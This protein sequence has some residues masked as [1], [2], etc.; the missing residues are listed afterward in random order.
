MLVIDSILSTNCCIHVLVV[1]VGADRYGE[2]EEYGSQNCGEKQRTSP[3]R[4]R[5]RRRE[6]TIFCETQPRLILHIHVSI[7]LRRHSGYNPKP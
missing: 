6:Y 3:T 7:F 1:D 5:R 4:H 2:G